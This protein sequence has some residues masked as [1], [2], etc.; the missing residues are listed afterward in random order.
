MVKKSVKNGEK[1]LKNAISFKSNNAL[2]NLAKSILN[3]SFQE[4]DLRHYSSIHSKAALCVVLRKNGKIIAYDGLLDNKIALPEKVLYA[5]RVAGFE[6]SHLPDKERSVLDVEI[7][8]MS[9]P[10]IMKVSH[11]NEYLS[12]IVLKRDGIMIVGEHITAAL[13]PVYAEFHKLTI[14]KFLEKLCEKAEL[15]KSDWKDL[16]YKILLFSV[17]KVIK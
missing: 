16:S 14:K 12:K 4:S 1:S 6:I 7:V 15:T 8:L 5:T 3:N 13:M 11:A 9:H 17:K 2:I 10:K